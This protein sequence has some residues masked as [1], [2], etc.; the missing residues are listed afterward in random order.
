MILVDNTQVLMSAIFSQRMDVGSIDEDLVRH[1]VLNCYRTYRN[2][3]KTDYGELVIC[4]DSGPS[5]RQDY[6]PHYKASR[7]K[8]RKDNPD[9]WRRFYEIMNTIQKEVE[10]IFPYK[11]LKVARC[12]ADD[13]IGVMCKNFAQQEPILILSGDKDFIQLHIHPDVRQFSPM[14][15]KFITDS[16]PK[17]FLFEHILRGDSSDGVP[18]ILSDDDVFIDEEK[19]QSPVTKKRISEILEVYAQSGTV[20]H[21]Y[22]V[23]WNRN[24]TL[25]NLLNTPAQYESQILSEWNIPAKKSRAKV[26]D[27]M[28]HKGLRNLI[29]DVGDF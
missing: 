21:K 26:L 9:T 8:T 24:S 12:E 16:N 23:N 14:Q 6:F 10:E 2:K 29:S 20:E 15:K 18:N 7:K 25:I 4:Q 17:N 3:F 19:R 1:I 11:T 27:Y 22:E 5:W 28:I 13:I